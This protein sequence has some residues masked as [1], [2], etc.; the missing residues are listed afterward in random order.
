MA[1]FPLG[2]LSAAGGGVVASDYE[3]IETQI[4]GSAQASVT[5][6]SL[7]IYSSTYKHLQIRSTS[8]LTVTGSGVTVQTIRFN[9][10]AGSNYSRHSLQGNGSSVSSGAVANATA[11]L[12]GYNFNEGEVGFSG[13]V[14]EILDAFSTTKNKTGRFLGGGAGA[15]NRFIGLY[16]FAWYNTSA[17][18]SIVIADSDGSNYAAG[19]RFSLYGIRG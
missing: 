6:S 18:S 4:L 19:S 8:R 16:S 2:I 14:C 7:G 9:G 13:N 5:F 11:G 15:S 3:L 17:V 10:D 1:L 12:S